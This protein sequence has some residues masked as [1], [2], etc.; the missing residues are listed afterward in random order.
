[1][2][3][4]IICSTNLGKIREFNQAFTEILDYKGHSFKSISDVYDG[5]F[6]VIEDGDSFLANATL[7]AKAGAKV[8]KSY[9]L[10]D[11]SGTELAALNGAPGIYSGR[12]MRD[13]NKGL[14]GIMRE[15][16][17]ETNR[18]ARYV[19][20][21]VL[22]APSGEVIFD[23]QQYWDCLVGDQPKGEN[24]FGFDPIMYPYIE[25]KQEYD[26]T[27]LIAEMSILEKNQR[28]HR[29]QAL[30]KLVAYLKQSDI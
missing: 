17:D 25:E 27:R 12:Y 22:C 9:C 23:T 7:K 1:M 10:A 6:D 13:P 21:L 19:C 24:G 14:A 5:E 26:T 4:I 2:T 16:K 29:T 3:E 8:T 20:C 28:S 11:D 18:Q 15:M 30:R